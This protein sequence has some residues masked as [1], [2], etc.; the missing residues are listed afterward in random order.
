MTKASSD[1]TISASA[2]T[3]N[4]NG[5]YVRTA[6]TPPARL[7]RFGAA[8]EESAIASKRDSRIRLLA[9]DLDAA[10][11]SFELGDAE[12]DFIDEG[13]GAASFEVRSWYFRLFFIMGN[14]NEEIGWGL[15]THRNSPKE[16]VV[17]SGRMTSRSFE[18]ILG[19]V[20]ERRRTYQA[21]ASGASGSESGL[22][23]R[24]K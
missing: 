6:T 22:T 18:A 11:E 24:I 5:E 19:L 8:L 7:D 23:I 2:S 16:G 14:N 1:G 20:L 21:R 4:E 10:L 3:S 13:D 12:I 17:A 9:A 15:A